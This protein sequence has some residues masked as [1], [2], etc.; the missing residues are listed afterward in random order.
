[1]TLTCSGVNRQTG[2]S[3]QSSPN[4]SILAKRSSTI[5]LMNSIS[6][7]ICDGRLD[8]RRATILTQNQL[9]RLKTDHDNIRFERFR[10][11]ADDCRVFDNIDREVGIQSLVVSIPAC[12]TP[13]KN[14]HSS[15]EGFR[16]LSRTQWCSHKH[17]IGGCANHTLNRFHRGNFDPIYDPHTNIKHYLSTTIF[18]LTVAMDWDGGIE[19]PDEFVTDLFESDRDVPCQFR[20]YYTRVIIIIHIQKVQGIFGLEELA[21]SS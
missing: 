3:S 2:L 6:C 8:S 15:N 14:E 9:Y 12:E 1:M 5:G 11:Y 16:E 20:T 19:G 7:R 17:T 13:S 21:W 10:K 4:S 18:P